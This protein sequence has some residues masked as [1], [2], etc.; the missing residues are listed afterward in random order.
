[1]TTK[2]ASKKGASSHAN[3]HGTRKWSAKVDTESTFPREELFKQPAS[4]IAKELASTK[5]S[6]KGPASGMRMLVFYV[7]RAGKNL[8][9][10]RLKVLER[11]KVLLHKYVEEAKQKR[12]SGSAS[13]KQTRRKS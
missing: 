5:V 6:P 12:D 3:S 4:T 9:P 10:T 2:K 8:S 11:A 13:K 7:N 1:M